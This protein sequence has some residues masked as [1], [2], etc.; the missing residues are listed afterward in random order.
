MDVPDMDLVYR[1]LFKG[2]SAAFGRLSEA[3]VE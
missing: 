3:S 1:L 2:F